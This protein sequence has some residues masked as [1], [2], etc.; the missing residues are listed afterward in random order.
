MK[1]SKKKT[2]VGVPVVVPKSFAPLDRES[3]TPFYFQIQTQLADRIRAGVLRAGETLPG[4]EELSRIF[5]VSRM[6]SRQALQALKSE[7]MAYRERGRGTFVLAP[8]VEK[9]ITNR[10][11]FTGEMLALGK[12]ATAEVLA[13][14]TVPASPQMAERLGLKSGA[15]VW[16]LRRL[17][18]ADGKPLAIEEAVLPLDRVP[19]IETVD[20]TR[21]SLY[22]TLRGKYG[23]R[24][25]SV[26]EIIEARPPTKKEAAILKMPARASLLAITRTLSDEAGKPI[27]TAHSLYRGDLYRAV[28]RIPAM[29]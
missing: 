19:G 2:S 4:E 14:K 12:S 18:F 26:D 11:G 13:T 5:G 22:E 6:T 3:F 9:D 15:A 27:E 8:K 28:L 7:G 16:M 29:P 21:C 25:G 1:T 24:L 17:R 10:V 23:I 20:F